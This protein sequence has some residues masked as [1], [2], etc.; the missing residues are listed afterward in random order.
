[1]TIEDIIEDIKFKRP[2]DS[3]F[4]VL[5]REWKL[6][7]AENKDQGETLGKLIVYLQESNFLNVWSEA[8]VLT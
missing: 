6:N 2:N 3:V 8:E 7:I 1:M 4:M 5:Y